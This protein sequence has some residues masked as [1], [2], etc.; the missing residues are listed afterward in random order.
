MRRRAAGRRCAGRR[1]DGRRAGRRRRDR[2]LHAPLSIAPASHAVAVRAAG[3]RL[4][5]DNA[6]WLVVPV[7]EEVRVLCVAG[8]EGAAKYVADALNPNPAGD[9][10]IRPVVVSEGDLAERGARRFRLRLPVQRRPA[11]RRAKPSDSR[12]TRQAGGGVV[13]FLGDRVIPES[14]NALAS[15]RLGSASRARKSSSGRSPLPPYRRTRSHQPQFGLDPLDYRHPIVAPFRGR[16][17]AGLLTTPVARYYRLELSDRPAR[18]RSRR[19]TA[20]AAIRSSWPRR[21]VAAAPCSSPPM[22]RSHP[23]TPNRRTLDHLANLAQLSADRP[24][25]AGLRRRR[26]AATMAATRRHAAQRA[27]ASRVRRNATALQLQIVR[28]D[29]RTDPSRMQ[30]ARRRSGV[31]LRRHRLSAASTRF[32]ALPQN[33]SQQFAVNVDTRK[34]T[35]RKSIRSSCHPNSSSRARG[36]MPTRT[37]RTTDLSRTPAGT[38]RC[39]G[40]R[41]RC[42][43]SNR[44]WPGSSAG[45][46]HERT[47]CQPGWPIGSACASPRPA[48]RAT[49]QLD[50]AWSWAP[51]ATLLLVLAAIVWTVMLYARE[52]SSAGRRVSR[53]ARRSCG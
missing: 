6:R 30:I 2:S 23:S 48:T 47:H 26:P 19:R 20:A 45:G 12:A 29:G 15:S 25:A 28:P 5:I 22:A 18:R 52:S 39:C 31:E 40:P 37:A 46:P 34:A 1:A 4:D 10:P 41:L 14:Y 36:K 51:W 16:E 8:R 13:F 24:R 43:S 50:S 38:S 11:H 53:A 32:A 27:R 44:S 49:W 35:S 33:Q 42:C 9:S 3:D 7:R 21:S 17:R